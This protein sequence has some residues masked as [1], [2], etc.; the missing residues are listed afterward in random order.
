M[1]KVSFNKMALIPGSKELILQ[2]N[3]TNILNL[4]KDFEPISR[5]GLS[6]RSK[7][8]LATVCKIVDS[9]IDIGLVKEVG[10]GE[11]SGG[12]RPILLQINYKS[13]YLV[14]IK[15]SENMVTAALTDLKADLI[16]TLEEKFKDGESVEKIVNVISQSYDHVIS[17]SDIPKEKVLGLGIGLPGHI[18]GKDGI[19]R[20][21]S[22]LGWR[23]VGLKKILQEK[24]NTPVLIENDVNTLTIAE[25]Y[26]GVGKGIDN[27]ICVTIGR[28]I[29]SGIVVGG[30]F[31]RGH[32]GAAGEFGHIT[33]K[34]DG[35]LCEC[36]S[37]GCLESISSELA[38]VRR[39]TEAIRS[40]ERS[41]LG[42]ILDKRDLNIMDV[43]K[44]AKDGDKLSKTVYNE[45]GMYLGIGIANLTNLLN[46]QLIIISGEG[47]KAED[48]LFKF[49]K[50]SFK[51]HCF[52]SLRE[53][54]DIKIEKLGN[55]AWARGAAT[56]VSRMVFK[57]P[58]ILEDK[59]M[60]MAGSH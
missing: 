42:D 3:T 27:F 8:S 38:I 29:G 59:E 30:E 36:G 6:K 47:V 11:S 37:R 32:L 44:A 21:S 45:A 55:Y 31:Y 39:T 5:T 10:E 50:K 41:S 48:L 25:K 19:V 34:K 60:L 49:M 35:P 56:L 52:P 13:F 1:K 51:E 23:N 33:V 9:L 7:L 40:G 57:E 22:I 28:G 43:I 12:R 24:L 14:G 18:D 16:T 46:P 2:I 17:E 54:T 53:K 15:L 26:F 20:Y 4:I 58:K